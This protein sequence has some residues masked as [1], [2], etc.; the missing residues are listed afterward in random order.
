M[1][2]RMASG[3]WRKEVRITPENADVLQ[4]VQ[5]PLGSEL[6]ITSEGRGTVV[7][8]SVLRYNV[9]DRET[10]IP[11]VFEITVDY[12]TESV[13]VDD[14]IAVNTSVTFN[15]PEEIEAGMVVLDIAVPTGFEPVR[16]T[17]A[18]LVE[19]DP[20]FKRFEIAGRKVILYIDNLQAG[21][22]LAFAFQARAKYPVRAKEVVSQ[23]YSYYRPE[24]RG[25]T[26]GGALTV[27]E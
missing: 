2:V 22:T 23:A 8:Q 16:E 24:Q 4:V 11:D 13:E 6:V 15:P 3:D 19:A 26:L 25:D 10:E 1:T 12:G 27:T 5:V 7:L 14:L 21:Q 20:L 18:A 9:P 17:V